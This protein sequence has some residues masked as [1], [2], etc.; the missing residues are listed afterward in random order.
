MRGDVTLAPFL[1]GH[2]LVRD[3][4]NDRCA[5]QV[6]RGP[7]ICHASL[8]LWTTGAARYGA[9]YGRARRPESLYEERDRLAKSEN[10]VKMLGSNCIQ[11]GGDLPSDPNVYRYERWNQAPALVVVSRNGDPSGE[12]IGAE[13]GEP[14]RQEAAQGRAAIEL[15]GE[16]AHSNKI[17]ASR[18]RSIDTSRPPFIYSSQRSFFSNVI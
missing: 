14:C 13:L 6:Q 5:G 2:R 4:V 18:R 7:P 17:W 16:N 3:G 8:C 11:E 15:P 1:G 10:L 9:T 12:S